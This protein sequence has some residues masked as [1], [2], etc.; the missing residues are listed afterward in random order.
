MNP[1]K[2]KDLI[3]LVAKDLNISE[4]LVKDVVDYF[5]K[6]VSNSLINMEDPNVFIKNLGTFKAIYKE[7]TKLYNLQKDHM[8]ALDNP[9]SFQQMIIK[10]DIEEKH[11]K[12]LLLSK[13]VN[14]NFKRKKEHIEL[15]NKLKDEAIRNLEK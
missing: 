1:I 8:N 5:Y 12:L 15:K 6:K 3:P 14:V 13:K 11:K 9:E 2:A 10:K 7:I 4:E